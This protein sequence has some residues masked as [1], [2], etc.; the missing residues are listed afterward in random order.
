MSQPG[1]GG[2]QFDR[3]QA[4]HIDRTL[5]D[6]GVGWRTTELTFWITTATL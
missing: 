3:E 4:E 1:S 6:E 2:D 5:M